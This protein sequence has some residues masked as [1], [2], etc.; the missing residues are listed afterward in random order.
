MAAGSWQLDNW[1]LAA[2]SWQLPAGNWQLASDGL[3]QNWAQGWEQG[4]FGLGGVIRC[5]V[6]GGARG[7]QGSLPLPTSCQLA[8]P[9]LAIASYILGSG[10]GASHITYAEVEGREE[11]PARCSKG[12]RAV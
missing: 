6:R 5:A 4:T 3:S 2:G 1:Q 10:L 7:A 9:E 12:G 11:Y 8:G